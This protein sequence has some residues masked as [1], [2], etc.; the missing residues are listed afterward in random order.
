MSI[1]VFPESRLAVKARRQMGM[2]IGY[3]IVADTGRRLNIAFYSEGKFG[4]AA[5][6]TAI[7]NETE[8]TRIPGT[9]TLLY[10]KAREIMQ[11]EAD[12]TGETW[13]YFFRTSDSSMAEWALD[14]EKGRGIF[15]W[16]D[17]TDNRKIPS[18]GGDLSVASRDEDTGKARF[19]HEYTAI[20]RAMDSLAHQLDAYDRRFGTP[21]W[22]L[23][24][25]RPIKHEFRPKTNA[26]IKEGN[27]P[28]ESV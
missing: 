18:R 12:E 17:Y 26:L 11:S 21:Y 7:S 19:T 15:D 1:E 3:Q 23:S 24:S 14:P 4:A 5:V 2:S 25:S 10:E 27:H 16:E 8:K 20:D 13:G 9:T 28:F 22:H 6:S